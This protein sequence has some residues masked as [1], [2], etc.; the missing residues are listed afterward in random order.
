MPVWLI[1]ADQQRGSEAEV[2]HSGRVAVGDAELANLSTFADKASLREYLRARNPSQPDEECKRTSNM[3]WRFMHKVQRNDSVLVPVG[4]GSTFLMGTVESAYR[5]L[6]D[7]PAEDRHSR[8]VYWRSPG[9]A[10]SE[11]PQSVTEEA[12]LLTQVRPRE[13]EDAVFASFERLSQTGWVKD[14]LAPE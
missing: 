9:I 14:G 4:D 8:Q 2:I 7:A 12:G 5:Y 3:L 6:P 13:A 1:R 10:A 11:L